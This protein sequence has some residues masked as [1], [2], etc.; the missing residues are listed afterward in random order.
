M[1]DLHP[2]EKAIFVC[3]VCGAEFRNAEQIRQHM[4]VHTGDNL[5]HPQGII[6]LEY[7]VARI[8]FIFKHRITK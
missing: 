5:K 2:K 8:T 3:D 4:R 6:T 1:E 7:H